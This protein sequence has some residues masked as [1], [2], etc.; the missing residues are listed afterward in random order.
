VAKDPLTFYELCDGPVALEA[1]RGRK[2]ISTRY[3]SRVLDHS[4]PDQLIEGQL[5]CI[6][7]LGRDRYMAYTLA[8]GQRLEFDA[9]MGVA[10]FVSNGVTYRIRPLT[11]AERNYPG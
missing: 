5:P 7:I 10:T 1:Y 9:A 6:E 2:V 4:Q 8:E 3:A 11:S